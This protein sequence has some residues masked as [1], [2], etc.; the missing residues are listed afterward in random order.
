M[1]VDFEV[2]NAT[3]SE[4][5]MALLMAVNVTLNASLVAGADANVN[6]LHVATNY[7]QNTRNRYVHCTGSA[8]LRCRIGG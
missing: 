3:L 4:T 5:E 7:V 6:L 1:T 8:V 2:L